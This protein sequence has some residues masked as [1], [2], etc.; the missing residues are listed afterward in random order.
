MALKLKIDRMPVWAATIKDRPGGLQAKLEPL[1]KAG[2]N[3]EF[4]IARRRKK[5]KTKTAVVFVTP[6][7]N[8]K[9]KAAARKAGFK[10]AKGL[11]SLRVVGPNRR[12]LGAKITAAMAEAGIN[13]R[14]LSAAV[15]KGQF[16][17]YLAFDKST[18]AG[19]ATRVMKKL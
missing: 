12:G 3:L 11:N 8:A 5:G 4:V 19:K 2:A 6:L 18:D 9:Q 1:A 17:M 15:L 7:K 14:G 13:L 16:V 10:Q